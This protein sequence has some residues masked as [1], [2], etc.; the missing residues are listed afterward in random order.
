MTITQAE[1][2]YQAAR[3][4]YMTKPDEA[5]HLAM[6]EASNVVI[7]LEHAAARKADPAAARRRAEEW[8]DAMWAERNGLIPSAIGPV[9]RKLTEGCA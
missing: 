6:I 3:A 9:V 4:A 2:K 1:A 7:R 8:E 5:T